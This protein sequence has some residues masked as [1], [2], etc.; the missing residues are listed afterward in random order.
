MGNEKMSEKGDDIS[1]ILL[2]V[3][4]AEAEAKQIIES[5]HQKAR[6][7]IADGDAHFSKLK[8]QKIGEARAKAEEKKKQALDSL[9]HEQEKIKKEAGQEA[10]KLETLG[11]KN[12]PKAIK[13]VLEAFAAELP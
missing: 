13:K 12:L 5:A 3:K 10:K 1:G 6:Q 7:V 2:S 9:S 8:E 4:G 11:Q